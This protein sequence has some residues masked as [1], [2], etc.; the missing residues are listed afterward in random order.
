M[1]LRILLPVMLLTA[2]IFSAPLVGQVTD[3]E[4]D[5]A[6]RKLQEHLLGKQQNGGW[7]HMY[8]NAHAGETGV[9]A[10]VTYALVG[11][12]VPVQHPKIQQA[13]KGM[14]ETDPDHTYEVGLRCHAWGQ[15]PDTY[16]NLMK[17]DATLLEN[18][19]PVGVFSYKISE[20]PKSR[21]SGDGPGAHDHSNTQYGLLGLWEASKRGVKVPPGFWKDVIDHFIA[22]QAN[23]GGWNYRLGDDRPS[24]MNMTLA[25]VTA[26]LVAQQEIHRGLDKPDAKLQASINKGLEWIDKNYGADDGRWGLYGTYGME[27]VGLATGI[28]Y[29]NNKDWFAIEATK[30]VNRVNQRGRYSGNDAQ[31]Y[32]DCFALLFLT[33]GRVPVWCTKLRIKNFPWNNRP[34]DI[35]FFTKSLSG[36]REGE[37]NFQTVDLDAAGYKW[38]NAPIAW[39]S[40]DDK[41]ELAGDQ[42]ARLKQFLDNGG[43]LI[44]NADGASGG[45]GMFKQS[46]RKLAAE[47]YPD[48]KMQ[49]ATNNH[50]MFSVHHKIDNGA[51]LNINVLNNGAR[52]LIVMPERDWGMIFQLAKEDDQQF[53]AATNLFVLSTERARLDNRMAVQTLVKK[54]G[55]AKG[56]ITVGRA[57]YDGNWLPEPGVW[58]AMGVHLFNRNN[59]ELKVEDV[60]L[61]SIGSSTI[62][63]IHL[64]GADAI[65]LSDAQKAAIKQ[66]VEGGGTILVE[67]VGGRRKFGV[68]L[69]PQ[70][71]EALSSGVAPLGSGAAILSG[72]DLTGGFDNK[73]VTYR[74]YT[75]VWLKVRNDPRLTSIMVN[76]RPAIILSHEDLSLGALGVR[77][78]GVLGYSAN[79]ARRLLIN[80]IMYAH[81]KPW[82]KE[83]K[84]V[85]ATSAKADAQ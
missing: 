39:L 77:R 82:M 53:R 29:F 37:L 85:E 36:I 15:F 65:K 61:A 8:D 7:G 17:K 6:I 45:S 60:D 12:G 49:R 28:K 43:M 57:K 80:M 66:Y 3:D 59:H 16:L 55:E 25:G 84:P 68:E 10:M 48:L 19:A 1:Q 32:D 56:T 35:Y 78:E 24:Y 13:I 76:N 20:E 47:L 81:E 9:T 11:S 62:P 21:P 18:T 5:R 23:D 74:P 75:I 72:K 14:S 64:A 63:L 46:I 69:E 44:A 52:D 38:F 71:V 51:A 40:G 27:R 83:K 70:L 4:I 34:N 73:F 30:I 67:T 2:G 33:R 58:N 26:Q 50:P 22:A 79:S 41:L 42:Q 31:V 54:K